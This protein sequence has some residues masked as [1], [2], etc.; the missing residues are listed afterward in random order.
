MPCI[1]NDLSVKVRPWEFGS[2]PRSL[3]K[4]LGAIRNIKFSDKGSISGPSKPAGCSES[5]PTRSLV[6]Q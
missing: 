6:N 3:R 5:E 1:T 4:M 2:S